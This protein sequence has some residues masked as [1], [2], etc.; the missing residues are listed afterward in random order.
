MQDCLNSS[1]WPFVGHKPE[2]RT[3]DMAQNLGN[4]RSEL[5]DTAELLAAAAAELVVAAEPWQCLKKGCCSLHTSSGPAA[6]KC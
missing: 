5:V 4:V 1:A 3:D 6:I 2:K